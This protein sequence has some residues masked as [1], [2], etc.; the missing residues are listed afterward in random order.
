MK[1]YL[2]MGNTWESGEPLG[3]FSS[4]SKAEQYIKHKYPKYIHNERDDIWKND[5]YDSIDI[6]EVILD[7]EEDLFKDY[8]Q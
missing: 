4:K 6:T 8:W 2:V 7:S 3:I 5:L 1:V